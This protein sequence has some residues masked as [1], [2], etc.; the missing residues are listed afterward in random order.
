[1]KELHYLEGVTHGNIQEIAR[2]CRRFMCW[3]CG[4]KHESREK[5]SRHLMSFHG[6]QEPEISG[7]AAVVREDELMKARI[8]NMDN[9]NRIIKRY[10]GKFKLISEVGLYN[11]SGMTNPKFECYLCPVD[12]EDK[13]NGFRNKVFCT[14]VEAMCNHADAHVSEEDFV[15]VGKY[16]SMDKNHPTYGMYSPIEHGMDYQKGR[17]AISTNSRTYSVTPNPRNRVTRCALF[18]QYCDK[19]N[20]KWGKERSTHQKMRTRTMILDHQKVCP[21]RKEMLE[22]WRVENELEKGK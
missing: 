13:K 18:C 19:Y 17:L 16:K 6:Y 22:K 1:M 5:M 15:V 2:R 8:E 14:P 4:K 12:K 20:K 11:K 3:K 10:E 21:K 9:R 7:D